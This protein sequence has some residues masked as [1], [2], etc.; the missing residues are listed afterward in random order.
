MIN[1]NNPINWNSGLNRGLVARWEVDYLGGGEFRELRR[2]LPGTLQTGASWSI[3]RPRGMAGSVELTGGTDY[4]QVGDTGLVDFLDNDFTLAC[5]VKFDNTAVNQT[6]FGK[7]NVGTRQIYFGLTASKLRIAYWR[8]G[9]AVVYLDSDASP[10]T[11]GAWTFLV[12]QRRNDNFEIYKNGLLIKSGTTGGSHGNMGANASQLRLGARQYSGFEDELD[13]HLAS[14]WI[15]GKRSLCPCSVRALYEDT[16]AGSPR[17]LNHIARPP[18]NVPTV[19]TASPLIH[20]RRS[21]V[22]HIAM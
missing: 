7:D 3:D 16:R 21:H 9:G 22:P 11:Q 18:V 15:Y 14:A 12:G 17:T 10:V 20:R 4:I 19:A 2:R 6:V 5:W 8:G 13:G 1:W